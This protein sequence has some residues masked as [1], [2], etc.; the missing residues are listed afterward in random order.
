MAASNATARLMLAKCL[1][2]WEPHET[3]RAWLECEAKTKIAAC[4]RRW[5]K[6]EAAAVDAATMAIACP[7]TVQMIVSPTY[8]QSRLIFNHVERLALSS[9]LTRRLTRVTRTPYPRLS[10]GSSVIMART[11]DDDGRNLRGHSA[12]RVIVDEAAYVRDSVITEVIS[13]MLA[14][15]DG[16]LVMV[17][18]PFGKNHFYRAFLRGSSH[19][20][21]TCRSGTVGEQ[22]ISCAS[23]RF[24]SWANPHI[25]RDYI[26]RQRLELSARQFAVEYEAQFLDDQSSV[27]LWREIEAAVGRHEKYCVIHP[28]PVVVG[29]DWA[30]YSDYTAAVAVGVADE[31]C[32]VVDIDQFNG[33]GWNSQIARV[34]DFIRNN[35]ASVVLTDQTSI[36][37]PLIEQLRTAL[38][39]TGTDC[40]V[41]GITFTNQS[42]RELIDY[43]SMRFA[44]GT[45]AVP[46]DDRLISELQYYEYELTQSGNV[47]WNA[48]SGYHDDLV[49]ALALACRGI[50]RF[51]ASARY[52]TGGGRVAAVGW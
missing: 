24:P 41:E 13:P 4:G 46:R 16:G 43:L 1:W 48:R 17:S 2:G 37:D 38:A 6:T 20:C 34:V 36:G 50:S 47:R 3:Q 51:Q 29:V 23:F 25:S 35:C 31:V 14:D 28:Q 32:S 26:E 40:A 18:T 19:L 52:L 33:L 22:E 49:T 10:I 45:I 15:R 9:E 39:E 7:G 11:A 12:D 44:H 30:R 5:G 8:D 42:K 27:F 21:S